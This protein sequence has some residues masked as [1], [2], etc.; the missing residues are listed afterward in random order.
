M[1]V[2]NS[3]FSE[4]PTVDLKEDLKR[5][6]ERLR[7]IEKSLDARPAMLPLSAKDVFRNMPE[8][9]YHSWYRDVPTFRDLFAMGEKPF[10]HIAPLT[11]QYLG[12]VNLNTTGEEK[13]PRADTHQPNHGNSRRVLKM[14]FKGK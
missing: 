2:L 12:P 1:P 13:R 6:R 10:A 4:P 7:Q 3:S 9:L 11:R 5:S 8:V 14:S